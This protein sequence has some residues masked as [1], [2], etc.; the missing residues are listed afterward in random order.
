MMASLSPLG[1]QAIPCT[2][3]P[4]LGGGG[5]GGQVVDGGSTQLMSI[6]AHMIS[7]SST[8]CTHGVR[9]VHF[10]ALPGPV[11]IMLT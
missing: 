9:S 7:C 4:T 5:G 10:T 11:G 2:A 3:P 6:K 8:M 1:S